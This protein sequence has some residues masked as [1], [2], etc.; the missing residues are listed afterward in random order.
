M[1]FEDW[2]RR[3]LADPDAAERVDSIEQELRAAVRLTALP[4]ETVVSAE[5][6]DELLRDLDRPGERN[7]TLAR[8]AARLERARR[9]MPP[10]DES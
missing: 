3:V 2:E 7:A 10:A 9:P 6:F 5:Y 1:S 8:A 4:G